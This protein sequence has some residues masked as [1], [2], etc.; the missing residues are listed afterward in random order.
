MSLPNSSR[1][2]CHWRVSHLVHHK[3]AL[4]ILSQMLPKGCLIHQGARKKWDPHDALRLE[5]APS[6]TKVVVDSSKALDF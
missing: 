4:E 2:A 1:E 6:R 3:K 5:C